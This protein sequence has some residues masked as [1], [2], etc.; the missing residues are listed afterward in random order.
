MKKIYLIAMLGVAF[1]FTACQDKLDIPQK[2]VLTTETFYQT[3][4]DA[5]QALAA[6]YEQ[7]QVNTMGRTTLGPGIYTPARVLANHPGD[8]ICYGGEYYGDHEW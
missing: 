3:D 7:F 2:A 4:D 1:G 8:D 5:E 6:A